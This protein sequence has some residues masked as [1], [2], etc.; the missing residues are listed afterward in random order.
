M[1]NKKILPRLFTTAIYFT[2][3]LFVLLCAQRT[4]ATNSKALGW[5]IIPVKSEPEKRED[6]AFVEVDGKFYLIGGRG[7]KPVE[8]FDP[9]TNEWSRKGNTPLE[10]NHFQGVSYDHEIYV[11]G[12][13][14][15]R[16]PHEIPLPNIYIYN[17]ERDE[18]RKGAEIPE[19]RRRGSGGTVV[20]N[21]RIYMVCGIVDGHWQGSVTWLDEFNPSTQQWKT[22]PDAPHARDHF[23]AAVIN[24]SIYIAGGRR[25]SFATKNIA[26]L[27]ESALDVYDFK[28]HNWRTLPVNDSLPTARAGSTSVT[29]KKK[30]VVI[31]GESIAQKSSYNEVEAYDIEAAKWMTLPPLVTGRHD[32]Q[33]IVYKNRIYIVA[34]SANSGGGPDQSSIEMLELK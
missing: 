16:F 11:V 33:A 20:Y 34:G 27:T 8:V 6:C 5:K 21:D 25:T 17:P 4:D 7:I 15:G 24:N 28:K 10:I 18:W 1:I 23:H 13:M 2:L 22:L 14:T 31:G 32:S 12:G 3:S 9:V 29:Y 19:A 26:G 30:L